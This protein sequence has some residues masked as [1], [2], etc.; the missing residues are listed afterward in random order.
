MVYLDW[1]GSHV[2]PVAAAILVPSIHR[3]SLFE[4]CFRLRKKF[5][6]LFFVIQKLE[7]WK[8][9]VK[10]EDVVVTK[11]ADNQ[12]PDKMDIESDCSTPTFCSNEKEKNEFAQEGRSNPH[13]EINDSD[14]QYVVSIKEDMA[15]PCLH[16]PNTTKETSSIRRIQRRSIRRIEDIEIVRQNG[17]A[18]ATPDLNETHTTPCLF[19]LNPAEPKTNDNVKIEIIKELLMEL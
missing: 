19:D 3:I 11:F 2:I 18:M 13:D 17:V 4:P 5:V 12:Q 1:Q 14:Y 8:L 6:L 10:Q 15:Y 7:Y 9:G 16:S